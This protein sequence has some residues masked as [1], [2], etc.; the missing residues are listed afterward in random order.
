MQSA[1][2]KGYKLV[3]DNIKSALGLTKASS[4]MNLFG[5][6][7]NSLNDPYSKVSILIS[8]IFSL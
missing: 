5:N 7:E 1:S 6:D 4:Q 3:M 2:Y 8:Y